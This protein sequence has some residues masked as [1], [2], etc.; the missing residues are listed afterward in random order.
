M[1]QYMKIKEFAKLTGVSVRTLQ[2][3]DEVNVLAPAYINEHGHR[4]YDSGS[5]DRMFV[6]R[7]LKSMGMGLSDI[8]QYLSHS[9]F[10]IGHFITEEKRRIETAIT[11]LQLRL[12]RVSELEQRINAKQ[13]I[14][15]SILPLFTTVV[16]TGDSETRQ[17]GPF[18]LKLWNQFIRDLN[19]C[20]EH[21]LPSTDKR[22]IRCVEYWNKHI[23]EANQVS[24][25]MVQDAEQYYQHH[26]DSSYGMTKD[27]YNYLSKMVREYHL[28]NEG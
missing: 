9:G 15:A 24:E 13:E 2:Y 16:S 26:S 5:F 23:I 28:K 20:A 4:F 17:P 3:Y 10:D 8:H 14:T 22:A 21:Q 12:M 6:I 1:E 27:N 19:Y 18:N 11:D 25:K 7:S